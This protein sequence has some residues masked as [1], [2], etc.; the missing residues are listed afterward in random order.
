MQI[1]EVLMDR[2][3]PLL[4]VA[5]LSKILGRS[6]DGLR[7]SL[8]R[9]SVWSNQINNARLKLGHRVYFRTTEIAQILDGK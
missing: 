6:T 8:R 5:Q 7:L 3:G 2:Y 4:S 1:E 9:E